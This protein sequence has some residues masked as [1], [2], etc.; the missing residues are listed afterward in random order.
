MKFIK[1]FTSGA[2]RALHSVKALLI[3]WLLTFTVL[4]VFTYP[5]RSFTLSALGNT[6]ATG[7]LNDGFNI[8]FFADLGSALRPMLSGITA[9]IMIVMLIFFFLYVFMN[10]GLFDSLYSNK[11][12]YKA[13]SFFR[14]SAKY[15][16]SFLVVKLLVLL[17]I[18]VVMFIVLGLPHI[19]F[20]TGSEETTWKIFSITRIVAVIILPLFLLVADYSRVWL[21]AN[22]QRKVFRALAYGFKATFKSFLSSYFFMLIMVLVQGGFAL[23]VAGLLSA[24]VP[25]TGGG[26]FLLFLL[27]QVLF[28]IKLYLRAV[29]YGGVSELYQL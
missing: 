24:Y 12:S 11:F 9:G 18:L 8:S 13:S 4:A 16:L 22:G 1:A 3:I 10:G 29:R 17:M 15:F 28:I 5:L 27:S 19:L 25:V 21:V 26:L 14:S 20:G 6:T 2:L 23:M 7:L